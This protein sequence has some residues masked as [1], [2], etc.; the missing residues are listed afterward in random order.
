MIVGAKNVSFNKLLKLYLVIA[1]TLMV[2]AFSASQYGL[3]EDLQFVTLRG[4]EFFV[5]HSYGIQYP[6]DFAAHLFYIVLVI[7]VLYKDKLKTIGIVWMSLVVALC[8]YMTAN[9]LTTA[10][11]LIGFCA[12]CILV[13]ISI[14]LWN[15]I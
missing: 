8:A 6:T 11:C 2:V 14:H 10:L 7:A 13:A 15:I 9:A 12:L 3:I 1:V 5:R 4:E